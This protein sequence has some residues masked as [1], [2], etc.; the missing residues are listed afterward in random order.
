MANAHLE[1]FSK[2]SG[3]QVR[4]GAFSLVRSPAEVCISEP[5]AFNPAFFDSKLRDPRTTAPRAPNKEYDTKNAVG[6][7]K[8]R[9]PGSSPANRPPKRRTPNAGPP[10]CASNARADAAPKPSGGIPPQGVAACISPRDW[11]TA[12][13]EPVKELRVAIQL[14]EEAFPVAYVWVKPTASLLDVR[15]ILED[16]SYCSGRLACRHWAF[17]GIEKDETLVALE[18]EVLKWEEKLA[19][20]ED[21]NLPIH[22]VIATYGQELLSEN[23][24]Q[25]LETEVQLREYLASRMRSLAKKR[26]RAERGI[27]IWPLFP[28]TRAKQTHEA[29]F[30][31]CTDGK[32]RK[33]KVVVSSACH[34][35]TLP[36]TA[37]LR[38]HSV[39]REEHR[40]KDQYRV[41]LLEIELVDTGGERHDAAVYT[42]GQIRKALW[43]AAGDLPGVLAS[44]IVPREQILNVQTEMGH[45]LLHELTLC[46]DVA[47]TELLLNN[48][49]DPYLQDWRGQTP[50]HYAAQLGHRDLVALYTAWDEAA[51][52]TLAAHTA[53]AAAAAAY[54]DLRKEIR[55][56]VLTHKPPVAPFVPPRNSPR[57][58]TIED[59]QCRTALHA[60][61]HHGRLEVAVHLLRCGGYN[62]TRPDLTYGLCV[63]RLFAQR[64]PPSLA[65]A[66]G[67]L[68]MLDLWIDHMGLDVNKIVGIQKLT[69]MH[70]AVMAQ[71]VA[72]V[73]HLLQRGFDPNLFTPACPITHLIAH[74]RTPEIFFE[75]Y[76]HLTIKPRI[77]FEHLDSTGNTALHVALSRGFHAMSARLLNARQ[78]KLK[79]LAAVNKSGQ[80]A[81]H[82]AAATDN[83]EAVTL[84]AQRSD[85]DLQ[86]MNARDGS[87]DPPLGVAVCAGHVNAVAALL[88]CPNVEVDCLCSADRSALFLAACLEPI[89]VYRGANP[90]GGLALK[91]SDVEGDCDPYS[92]RSP[93]G[94]PIPSRLASPAVP[95]S[96]QAKIIMSPNPYLPPV[97]VDHADA[98][99]VDLDAGDYRIKVYSSAHAQSPKAQHTPHLQMLCDQRPN[100]EKRQQSIAM[101]LVKARAN[102]AF[103][104][105]PAKWDSPLH[106]IVRNGDAHLCAQVLA[107]GGDVLLRAKGRTPLGLACERAD[108][109]LI[110]VMLSNVN[111]PLGSPVL[112]DY[113]LCEG[114]GRLCHST[115]A[116]WYTLEKT[117]VDLHAHGYLYVYYSCKYGNI[118]LLRQLLKAGA[119]V[120]APLRLPN[121]QSPPGPGPGP[122]AIPSLRA[123][124]A[125]ETTP[126]QCL[127]QCAMHS[128][129]PAAPT[130]AKGEHHLLSHAEALCHQL[131]KAGAR[132]GLDTSV[133]VPQH[134]LSAHRRYA[135]MSAAH[136]ERV[137]AGLRR[138]AH[139]RPLEV[140]A[141][142]A[143]PVP[144]GAPPG[145]ALLMACVCN[146]WGLAKTLASSHNANVDVVEPR[147]QRT[148]L[149]L[150][151]LARA[152]PFARFLVTETDADI[153]RRDCSGFTALMYSVRLGHPHLTAV[154]LVADGL[155]YDASG[156]LLF[157]W[158]RLRARMAF[159]GAPPTTTR[160]S[161]AMNQSAVAE[162]TGLALLPGSSTESPP[163]GSR[164]PVSGDGNLGESV[165]A[166]AA[167]GHDGAAVSETREDGEASGEG[168]SEA[169]GVGEAADGEQPMAEAA[170]GED[171]SKNGGA[172]DGVQAEAEPAPTDINAPQERRL[173]KKKPAR[174][175]PSLLGPYTGCARIR[176]ASAVFGSVS[177]V[178]SQSSDARVKANRL[179]AALVQYCREIDDFLRPY[180][181][182]VEDPNIAL[183]L[184]LG[185]LSTG[186]RAQQAQRHNDAMDKGKA[187]V[188]SIVC[189]MLMR[190]EYTC[191]ASAYLVL[192]HAAMKGDLEAVQELIWAG[193]EI[194]VRAPLPPPKARSPWQRPFAPPHPLPPPLPESEPVL[195]PDESPPCPSSSLY[196][197][198]ATPLFVAAMHGHGRVVA[199]LADQF[200][201]D[202]ESPSVTGETP[203]GAALRFGH[204][205]V[206]LNLLGLGALPNP[207]VTR[208]G[209]V[210]H[211]YTLLDDQRLLQVHVTGLTPLAA[212]LPHVAGPDDVAFV[213]QLLGAGC[214]TSVG[215][216]P[217]Q[218][219]D[220]SARD[221]RSSRSSSVVLRPGS[222][223]V[224]GSPGFRDPPR[225]ASAPSRQPPL[226]PPRKLEGL[227]DPLPLRHVLLHPLHM[228]LAA[229]ADVSRLQTDPRLRSLA[230][231]V[232]KCRHRGP[233]DSINVS[234]GHVAEELLK[235]ACTIRTGSLMR[236]QARAD[237]LD[238]RGHD[239]VGRSVLEWAVRG[240]LWRLALRLIALGAD[241]LLP[242]SRVRASPDY[243]TAPARSASQSRRDSREQLLPPWPSARGAPAPAP[244]FWSARCP[245][246]SAVDGA[247]VHHALLAGDGHLYLLDV[248][249]AVVALDPKARP[250]LLA[251][252]PQGR[253]VFHAAVHRRR[254]KA[255]AQLLQFWP[256]ADLREPLLRPDARGRTA[257]MLAAARGQAD[258]VRALLGVWAAEQ[259][260][261]R[262]SG[263]ASALHY[264]AAAGS[265]ECLGLLRGAGGIA[266]LADRMVVPCKAVPACRAGTMSLSVFLTALWCGHAELGLALMAEAEAEADT[267]PETG[268]TAVHLAAYRGLLPVLRR[269]LATCFPPY[270]QQVN[271][272]GDSALDVAM[273]YHPWDGDVVQTLRQ[274]F[275]GAIPLRP[276]PLFAA[277]PAYP[278]AR[279]RHTGALYQYGGWAALQTVFCRPR[280]SAPPVD[281][282]A[283]ALDACHMR[284]DKRLMELLKR[285][286]KDRR[287]MR[288]RGLPTVRD[289]LQAHRQMLEKEA[290]EKALAE[291]ASKRGSRA[292]R[293][294]RVS[295]ARS[296][297]RGSR[298]PSIA[299]S[300]PSTAGSEA[301]AGPPLQPMEQA[302]VFQQM[303]AEKLLVQALRTLFMRF[304]RI[305]AIKVG[306][307][308]DEWDQT[309][310]LLWRE[311][312]TC[313]EVVSKHNGIPLMS[314]LF[315]LEIAHDKYRGPDYLRS[316]LFE[317]NLLH[318]ACLF[319]CAESMKYLLAF[320]TDPKTAV[321]RQS[322][323]AAF[324]HRES[325]GLTPA[326]VACAC[327]HLE[328][329]RV[330][331]KHSIDMSIRDYAGVQPLQYL[332]PWKLL[333]LQE[334]YG[335]KSVR[336]LQAY[337]AE[338]A[339]APAA[340]EAPNWWG[341]LTGVA[342]DA[343]VATTAAQYWRGVPSDLSTF[344]WCQ[345]AARAA[346][347]GQEMTSSPLARHAQMLSDAD[348]AGSVA[349]QL[350]TVREAVV[351]GVR[352]TVE[353][354]E[355]RGV[356]GGAADP[357]VERVMPFVDVALVAR[358][359]LHHLRY[360]LVLDVNVADIEHMDPRRRTVY[361]IYIRYGL[362]GGVL[363]RQLTRA[364]HGLACESG[365]YGLFCL[366]RLRELR[367]AFCE[368][369]EG[370]GIY[371]EDQGLDDGVVV[372][373]QVYAHKDWLQM[374]DLLE[375]LDRHFCVTPSVLFESVLRAGARLRRHLTAAG[376]PCELFVQHDGFVHVAELVCSAH[377][378]L[379]RAAVQHSQCPPDP[380]TLTLPSK[381]ST[382]SS[383]APAEG[384]TADD[385]D[386]DEP[387]FDPWVLAVQQLRQSPH[388]PTLPDVFR[389]LNAAL[390]VPLGPSARH[391]RRALR[392]NLG[393][394]ESEALRCLAEREGAVKIVF[395]VEGEGVAQPAIE[396]P[397]EGTGAAG[398]LLWVTLQPPAPPRPPA[399]TLGWVAD[400]G[401]QWRRLRAG[402]VP[403]PRRRAWLQPDRAGAAP[404]T[405]AAA[406]EART[407]AVLVQRM[408][409]V[410]RQWARLQELRA[411]A[412]EAP[413]TFSGKPKKVLNWAVLACVIE[414]LQ[415]PACAAALMRVCRAWCGDIRSHY[416]EVLERYVGH[417]TSAP[418][419][420]SRASPR[421]AALDRQIANLCRELEKY[422]FVAAMVAAEE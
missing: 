155:G 102:I 365:L 215:A 384:P 240:G 5:L 341:P 329:V 406:A 6:K 210:P 342:R 334:S 324:C 121:P 236:S 237:F 332:T 292:S 358:L 231:G 191:L 177:D 401:V 212:F 16:A 345:A 175:V 207:C 48:N 29:T 153:R 283:E 194:N 185:P 327:G 356:R 295:R 18:A 107:H 20:I 366:L 193:A 125:K 209:G 176:G 321:L 112:L 201:V 12:V 103:G 242:F 219:V 225:V 168:G 346:A 330:M 417:C 397:M 135:R 3:R 13:A 275:D 306:A 160:T 419:E 381:T 382:F 272:A 41:A 152:L 164:S 304:G 35:G 181:Y 252:D 37:F 391:P 30:R 22:S 84:I 182:T 1:P 246:G 92:V 353:L 33:P 396:A 23:E 268:D 66:R 370:V 350:G 307:D 227:A 369:L 247:C 255:L 54:Q 266:E 260:S 187:P 270:C 311:E 190:P 259:A 85:S 405:G 205:D 373:A 235:A 44:A 368:T 367:V 267:V 171:V 96:T 379:Q 200:A 179:C 214:K 8:K 189:A 363:G 124:P 249:E 68:A 77:F 420:D 408:Q 19:A 389:R 137:A 53:D 113:I 88:R 320:N 400:V 336:L 399:V 300:R 232:V 149:H 338:R 290:R 47:N 36:P 284:Q 222:G 385:D 372:T 89:R 357:E 122:R 161:V 282:E 293:A 172:A 362:G 38:G 278:E 62:V 253:T 58:H 142:S 75:Y 63:K 287:R 183:P 395:S 43:E 390:N 230:D 224:P 303:D 15:R 375:Q 340:A 24:A 216:H 104:G 108:K 4:A 387:R 360:A 296:R 347:E 335:K 301:G 70:H 97:A 325:R 309:A 271:A 138:A 144:D 402:A 364:L 118:S 95:V 50:L 25:R 276:D 45:S 263:G 143:D 265:K 46:N 233:T 352:R 32:Y 26:R 106:Q 81:L 213:K 244:R 337:V 105:A 93:S 127:L 344:I 162:G 72:S 377:A 71:Q 91:A 57:L 204:R 206:A 228:L 131:L 109:F 10:P 298:G 178:G 64:C 65:A 302:M 354:L 7:S 2:I 163:A 80:S 119:A 250:A 141:G 148:P 243:G 139:R 245:R 388:A 394:W 412:G 60:A 74:R 170:A 217:L 11:I 147:T 398:D 258:C 98:A 40:F 202:L 79:D 129:D 328:I 39:F 186:D 151:V 27:A 94:T 294:S 421:I 83:G 280:L 17:K 159:S 229:P 404:A 136:R 114:E 223:P 418:G 305:D 117:G 115:D 61:L 145:G 116:T 110:Q 111:G 174:G 51:T 254:P 221:T 198:G 197:P 86:V 319:G 167:E 239:V 14:H 410:Q 333:L 261:A 173:G 226:S 323:H 376:Q 262:T 339:Q 154:L 9:K 264:A 374:P 87:G 407:G 234:R 248:L 59:L 348:I 411:E 257:L 361:L 67:E 351:S 126:V 422:E 378:H 82:I 34:E 349:Q 69:V 100:A 273:C 134:H 416:P 90:L 146:M 156:T 291:E 359:V 326:H 165:G 413:L 42:H 409:T 56:K 316:P 208:F 31:A 297:S 132:P 355:A 49:A 279:L 403:L 130:T 331:L 140:L 99:D 285:G 196:P 180:L 55:H 281:V 308:E 157:N 251:P 286:E 317:P 322:V 166:G 188:K 195:L 277:F 343:P 76:T 371:I 238:L 383:L 218:A 133:G 21:D 288:I 128:C 269:L 392:Y 312:E 310:V 150:A 289:F 211:P 192:H 78:M 314:T 203:L 158:S 386:D 52:A 318:H 256:E 313:K 101:M 299:S 414:H 220:T 393:P 120:A 415:D 274:A 184:P 28:K 199:L 315:P 73:R 241:P 169:D 380:D 123:G